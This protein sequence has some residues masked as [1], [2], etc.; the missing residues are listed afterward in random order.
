MHTTESGTEFTGSKA[1]AVV[2]LLAA[3]TVV[4]WPA[5]SSEF[6]NFDDP[7]YVTQNAHVLHGLTCDSFAWA[8]RTGHA[9]N[10]HPLTWLSHMLDAQ[11]FGLRPGL[12]HLTSVFIHAANSLLVLTLLR[13]LT[14]AFWRSALVAALFA[15]HP[16]HVESV[17][18]IAERKDVLSTL[19]G[20]LSLLA[21][22]IYAQTSRKRTYIIALLL[23]ALGLMTKP[24]LV[25]LPF[26][27]VLLDLWPLRRTVQAR[28]VNAES[29]SR[30]WKLLLE[31]IPF[32]AL[33]AVSSVITFV[34]QKRSATVL[35]M[36]ALPLLPRL[37]NAVVAYLTYLWK[38]FWPG[39]LAV[40]YPYQQVSVFA[41][42]ASGSLLLAISV[43]A[44]LS[45]RRRPWLTVGWF[46]FL[47]TLVPVIGLVQVGAQALAD[48]Y[49]YIPLIGLA[50]ATIWAFSESLRNRK[51]LILAASV[52]LLACAFLTRVQVTY[53]HDSET[54]FSHSIAVTRGN[55]VAH[56]CLGGAYAAKGQV[57]KA[58]IEFL[59]AMSLKPG[60]T[61]AV[62]DMARLLYDQADFE[63]AARLFT[64]VLTLR[65]YDP[66]ALQNLASAL[67]AMG[68]LD[69][70]IPKY[71]EALRLAPE[72]DEA[73][74][75]LAAALAQ[76]QQWVAA[77][78]HYTRGAARLNAGDPKPAITEFEAA[79]RLRP[80]WPEL[81]NNLAWLLATHSSTE[82]R[83]GPKAVPLAERACAL[84]RQTNVWMLSTLAAAYAEA[85]DF[86]NAVTTQQRVCEGAAEARN[87]DTVACQERLDRYRSGHAYH[88]P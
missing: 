2:A 4:Y 27:L 84:T 24:M 19:F 1:G 8:F 49:T 23:F 53:W 52:A 75:N 32:F 3:I 6:I 70:A 25:T 72:Y 13:K 33:A 42:I 31:K 21:Y 12:H 76:R 85:N 35:S 82:V 88:Q 36:E 30:P 71:E 83:D 68:Q 40:P 48:R 87:V 47:G 81:L 5:F 61:H 15:L 18:W 9:A 74:E 57:G 56:D 86:T 79:L 20:L 60:F 51:A 11:L 38:F 65:P 62:S 46:W 16:L 80:D 54:L 26:L 28:T 43:V 22:V 34:V 69:K 64:K 7:D 17:A 66:E 50:L 73:R 78:E 55:Y 77:S 59:L 39:K 37:G 29:V 45:F 63:G 44:L 14:A 58:R 41:A 67:A 10:W